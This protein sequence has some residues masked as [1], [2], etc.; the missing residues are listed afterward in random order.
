MRGE[1]H[2]SLS[3]FGVGVSPSQVNSVP[4]VLGQFSLD[5][6]MTLQ[7]ATVYL[8]GSHE[9]WAGSSHTQKVKQSFRS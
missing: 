9:L 5:A 8:A 3:T 4:T 7:K 6:K 2:P 1:E